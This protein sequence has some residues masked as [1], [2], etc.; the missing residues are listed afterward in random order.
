MTKPAMLMRGLF[1]ALAILLAAPLGLVGTPALAV[2]SPAQAQQQ[3]LVA[4]VLFEGNQ[5]FSDQDLLNMVNV[6]EYGTYTQ[7]GLASDAEAIRVA[8]EAKGY[9]GVTVTPKVEVQENGRA[10]ITF[11]I[12]EGT[13]TGIAAINFTGNNAFSADTLKSVITTHETGLLS[14]LF[15]DDTYSEDKLTLDR[16]LIEKYYADRG[17]PDATVT[18]AVGEYDPS[19][20]AYFVNFTINEGEPY[21]FGKIGVET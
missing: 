2:T 11:V 21:R 20:N 16:Q 4:A 7:G 19:R 12:N 3:H 17:Y 10:V 13:R 9:V 6:G 14:W 8:Y 15:R 1:L 5:G 18:S